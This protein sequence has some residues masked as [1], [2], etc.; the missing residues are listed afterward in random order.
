MSTAEGRADERHRRAALT[1]IAS[2]AAKAVSVL[3]A[4]ISVPLTLHY[5]GVERY[6]MW[7]TMS[8]LVAMLNFADFGMGSGIVNAVSAAY[9]RGDRAAIRQYV[10]SGFVVLSAIALAI[11]TAFAVSYPFVNWYALFNVASDSAR[12]ESGPALAVLISCFALNI[13]VGVVQRVQLG[14][15]RGF[16]ASLW[17]CA[18]S[19]IGLIGI[20]A[21]V[22]FHAGLPVLVFA[23]VGSPI[24]AALLNIVVFFGWI[25]PDLAPRMHAVLRKSIGK[26]AHIGVLFFVLQVV[27]AISFSSDNIVIAQVLGAS[28]VTAYAVPQRMF[29]TVGMILNMAISPLW[30]AYGEAIS[31]ADHMWVARTFRRSLAIALGVSSLTAILL[32]FVGNP[33]IHLWVGQTVT[34]PILLLV[35]LGIWQI[36]LSCGSAAAMLL[37]GANVVRLQMIVAVITAI[38]T[39]ALKVVMVGEAGVSGAVWSTIVAYLLCAAFPIYWKAFQLTGAWLEVLESHDDRR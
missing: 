37:N 8:S 38:V 33:L 18:G 30:P 19:L 12:R 10:S 7:M 1:A 2:A 17:Q 26:I 20:I 23:Y 13:P 35:G 28:A 27:G 3:T 29:S 11:I 36:L 39:I 25:E 14:M 34:A 32:V 9:G 16:M 21:A 15:Q 22:A 6:G 5:L 31:R 24:I 4:L